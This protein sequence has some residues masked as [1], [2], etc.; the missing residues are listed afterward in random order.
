MVGGLQNLVFIFLTR[1][2]YNLS[3]FQSLR[4]LRYNFRVEPQLSDTPPPGIKIMA[5]KVEPEEI[6]LEAP[7]SQ[8]M[9]IKKVVTEPVSLSGV[10]TDK[11]V[12]RSVQIVPSTVLLSQKEL[13]KVTVTLVVKKTEDA[14]EQTSDKTS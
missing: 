6:I 5:L 14:P 9:K 7:K 12:V 3:E 10:S 1:R 2:I 13:P 11:K 4:S 8:L